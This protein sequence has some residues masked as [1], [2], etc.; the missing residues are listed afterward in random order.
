MG[1]RSRSPVSRHPGSP[2]SSHFGSEEGSGSGSSSSQ[3][4]ENQTPTT[5]ADPT[6]YWDE[7]SPDPSKT[8][9]SP[10]PRVVLSRSDT[11]GG[12]EAEVEHVNL[13]APRPTIVISSAR[14]SLAPVSL[15]A[16]GGITPISP[17]QRYP[18]WLSEVVRPLEEFIDEPVDPREVYLDLR[19]I[20]E[21][22]SGSVYQATLADDK[23]HR[24]KLP[25]LI[26]AQDN[27]NVQNG[28]KT[29][30]AIK[31]VAILPSGSEKLADLERE[32]KLLKGLMHPNI[33]GL[34]ALYVDLQEDSL[35]IRMELMERSLADVIGLVTEGL[36]LQERMMARFASD[37]L[38]ALVY[39]QSHGIAHRDVRS[40]NLLLNSHG[41]LKLTDFSNA[42][43]TTS[44]SS[45]CSDP[46]GVLYWQAPEVR[47][48]SY[49]PLKVDVWS[50]GATVWEMAEAEPPF[51]Q[52]SEAE[53]RWPPLTHPEVYSPAFREF[54][55]ACS[56]PPATR[57]SP[58]ELAK[59]PFISNSC[60]R[61]VIIQILS[62]CMAIEK[63]IQERDLSPQP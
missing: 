14:A 63:I 7:P 41:I 38:E 28:I 18:G 57:P 1:A 35:W 27:D 5:D 45:T 4:Q 20:A 50:L 53:D 58:A 6:L 42:I 16:S 49:N 8:S 30:V 44:Q 36:M 34:D 21:G 48:G 22:E 26:K 56:D 51:F 55:R 10:D 61:L 25:P 11:F 60:G 54:L 23:S 59:N 52:T 17:A 3:S 29:L 15:L 31:S 13:T 12:E 39:L 24:L 2:L 40:D 19:E 62:Q 46:V 37:V 33:L 32:L 47:C 9:F 43:Q